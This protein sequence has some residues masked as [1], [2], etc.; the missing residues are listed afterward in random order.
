MPYLRKNVIRITGCFLLLPILLTASCALSPGHH[1]DTRH[2]VGRSSESSNRIELIPITPK[3]IAIAQSN[4]ETPKV[5][6]ELLEYK[7]EEYC[8]GPSDVLFITVWDH[9]ELTAP[10]GMQLQGEANGRIVRP[11]GTLFYPYVGTV[12]AAG[13]TI[14]A[15]RSE[16]TSQLKRYIEKP[17]IDINILRFASQKI[18]LSGA[19][20]KNEPLFITTQPMSLLEAMG[21]GEP[22]TKNADLSS[23]TLIRNGKHFSLNMY[24]LTREPSDIQN[25]FLEDGD[26]LYLPFNDR[27]KV[28]LMGEVRQPKALPFTSDRLS[29]TEAIGSA[30]GLDQ[31][32]SKGKDVYVI[33]GVTDIAN[34]N[35]KIFQLNAKSPTAF[36]LAASFDLQPQDVI[37]V[38]PAGITRWNRVISQ[39]LPSLNV[40]G[41]TAQAASSINDISNP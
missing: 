20:L 3:L 33:R 39:L 15:L 31:L 1:I 14:E 18:T 6:Q 9:P 34:E 35:A 38:G 12:M 2:L 5:Q 19:F 26:T 27:K 8:I 25:V 16:L 7:P 10:S 23:L 11:D 22:D 37:Y 41:S 40:L 32:T 21:M 29:L 4:Y 36:A 24:A 17:Q 28:Y 30:G 13:K